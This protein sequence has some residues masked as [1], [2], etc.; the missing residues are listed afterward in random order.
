MLLRATINVK[1]ATSPCL[2]LHVH[3]IYTHRGEGGCHKV[4]PVER[5]VKTDAGSDSTHDRNERVVYRHL[6]YRV[7][8]DK[9]VVEGEPQ[10]R[11]GD[12]KQEV[13]KSNHRNPRQRT[14]Y[15]QTRHEEHESPERE[16]VACTRVDVDPLAQSPRE[17]RRTG[18][19]ESVEDDE[20]VALPCEPAALL[21]AHV[22]SHDT[23][24]T[25]YTPDNLVDIETVAREED[26]GENHHGEHP[27]TS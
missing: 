15:G 26:A 8:N 20:A 18:A 13:D 19:T 3:K 9:P 22:E 6:A 21:T 14:A 4:F 1:S 24:E 10:R 23:R 25:D 11:D 12:E 5:L 7:A 17:K 2:P 27:P 16:A